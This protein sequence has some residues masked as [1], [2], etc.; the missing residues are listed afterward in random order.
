MLQRLMNASVY[1]IDLILSIHLARLLFQLKLIPYATQLLRS[2][3]DQAIR[4]NDD[5]IKADVLALLFTISK[6]HDYD[7]LE[8]RLVALYH[9]TYYPSARAILSK[10]Y[11]ELKHVEINQDFHQ[12]TMLAHDLMLISTAYL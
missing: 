12:F 9:E 8:D 11:P 10:A 7:D 3:L 5:M 6:Q 4:L 1:L 2:S